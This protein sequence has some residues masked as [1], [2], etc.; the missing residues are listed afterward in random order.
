VDVHGQKEEEGRGPAPEEAAV[1]EVEAGRLLENWPGL[2]ETKLWER[3]RERLGRPLPIAVVRRW[4]RES[5]Y[6][7]TGARGWGGA[8]WNPP[9]ASEGVTA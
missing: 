3:A 2:P 1:L 7:E 9:P 6:V 8:I 4:L 5:G